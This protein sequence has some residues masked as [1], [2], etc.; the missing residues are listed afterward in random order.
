[1]KMRNKEMRKILFIRTEFNICKFHIKRNVN[2]LK[3]TPHNINPFS[4]YFIAKYINLSIHQ[5]ENVYKSFFS[6]QIGT[7]SKL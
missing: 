5:K 1:M 6:G 3:P 7:Q 4:S 2:A